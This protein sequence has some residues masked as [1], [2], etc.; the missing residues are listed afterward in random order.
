MQKVYDWINRQNEGAKLYLS[1][2]IA[3]SFPGGPQG[4][5][6]GNRNIDIVVVT[7][8]STS[9]RPEHI[10]LSKLPQSAQLHM[11]TWVDSGTPRVSFLPILFSWIPIRFLAARERTSKE[12]QQGPSP[13]ECVKSPAGVEEALNG[14][15]G[16]RYGRP[17]HRFGPPTAL[18]SEPL[19]LLKYELDH[20]E[21]YTPD[22]GTLNLAFLLITTSA[23]FFADEDARGGALRSLLSVFFSDDIEWQESTVE[24]TA[25]PYGVWFGGGFPCLIFELKNEQGLGGDPVLQSSISYG[26]VITQ[27]LVCSSL[28]HSSLLPLNHV[29]QYNKYLGQSNLPAVLLAIA[30]DRLTVSTAVYTNEIYVDELLSIPLRLGFHKSNDVLRVARVFMAMNESIKRLHTL[31]RGLIPTLRSSS[32]RTTVLW[33]QPTADPPPL[34]ESLPKLEFFTKVNRADGTALSQVDEENEP[35]GIY[36]ARMQIKTPPQVQES[37]QVVFVKFTP[38]YHE[39]AHRLLAQQ[40]PPLAP[41]LYFCGRVIGDVYMVVMEYIPRTE[42]RSIDR[43]SSGPALPRNLPQIVERDVSKALDLLHGQGLVFG[44][45]RAPNLLYLANPNGGRVMLVDFDGVARDGEGRYSSCLNPGAG[46]CSGV[47]R[48]MIMR[49]EH[50]R[51][52]FKE[53]LKRLQLTT[54]SR[55]R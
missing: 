4:A 52:N 24:K 39:D 11:G 15:H 28:S 25:K 8:E 7:P 3:T 33:P 18:F 34:T 9:L 27:K 16:P 38:K 13:S 14:P 6:P 55:W 37:T 47:D 26:K 48:G 46:Y 5:I 45:L 2:L 53:L 12:I 21:L 17:S 23:G 19:A 44:D 54:G 32:P 1:D 43:R 40:D 22:T 30:G 36:L 51:R 42:G 31:Y 20:L 10:P 29:V 50:D 35:H 49:K 41:A